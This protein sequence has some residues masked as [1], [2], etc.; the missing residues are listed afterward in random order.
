VGAFRG[1]SL[2]CRAD[3]R[4]ATTFHTGAVETARWNLLSMAKS[5]SPLVAK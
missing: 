5:K 3:E 2:P 1:L 4:R